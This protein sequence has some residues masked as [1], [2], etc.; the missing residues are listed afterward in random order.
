MAQTRTEQHPGGTGPFGSTT[1]ELAYYDDAGNPVDEAGATVVR[2]SYL[3][4][5][6]EQLGHAT[7]RPD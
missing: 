4:E 1:A 7:G 5:H 6:G 3:D 2:A